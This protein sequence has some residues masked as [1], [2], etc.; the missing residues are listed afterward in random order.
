MTWGKFIHYVN[1]T[2]FRRGNATFQ[3]F[4]TLSFQNYASAGFA[5]AETAAGA[6]GEDA[7]AISTAVTLLKD[8]MKAL[9]QEPGGGEA[10]GAVDFPEQPYISTEELLRERVKQ[11]QQREQ[12]QSEQGS[13]GGER[14]E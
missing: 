7:G 9:Q 12:Q 13:A 11:Q 3:T 6:A 5:G 1:R 2:Q 8:K 14:H 10:A 4:D